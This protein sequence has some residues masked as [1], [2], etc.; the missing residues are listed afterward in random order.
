MDIFYT[1]LDKIKDDYGLIIENIVYDVVNDFLVQVSDIEDK[2]LIRV[3]DALNKIERKALQEGCF[4]DYTY[5][6]LNYMVRNW[7]KVFME[8]PLGERPN[9]LGVF[10]LDGVVID[11][12]KPCL[13]NL[14]NTTYEHLK[15]EY[16]SSTY[17][18]EPYLCDD[19]Y[20]FRERLEIL[21]RDSKNVGN[22]RSLLVSADF[23]YRDFN[24]V[25]KKISLEHHKYFN[26]ETISWFLKEVVEDANRFYR[27]IKEND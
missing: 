15:G 22:N 13:D 20:Y 14:F 11:F 9:K 6:L 8:T 19:L 17:Y 18:Y 24:R 23:L 7:H 16:L 12:E 21:A 25:L 5:A 2:H 4:L 10:G 1:K 26:K 3:L 27:E